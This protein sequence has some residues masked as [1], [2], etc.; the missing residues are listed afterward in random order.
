[1]CLLIPFLIFFELINNKK[2]SRLSLVTAPP[3]FRSKNQAQISRLSELPDQHNLQVKRGF[4]IYVYICV[5]LFYYTSK[6]R[7]YK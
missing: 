4:Y 7:K 1:M 3:P 5:L 2:L 6:K